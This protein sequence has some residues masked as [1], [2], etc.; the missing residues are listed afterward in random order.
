M[1]NNQIPKYTIVLLMYDTLMIMLL[2]TI[3]YQYPNSL[4]RNNQSARQFLH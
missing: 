1:K 2:L 3:I 4:M